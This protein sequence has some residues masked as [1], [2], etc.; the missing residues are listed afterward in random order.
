MRPQGKKGKRKW[1][2][3]EQN[4]NHKNKTRGEGKQGG[5]CD[6]IK[7]YVEHLVCQAKIVEDKRCK[8][9]ITVN[10]TCQA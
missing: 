8:S 10:R 4:N 9:K 3:K 2:K 5:K 6:G 1:G 7:H